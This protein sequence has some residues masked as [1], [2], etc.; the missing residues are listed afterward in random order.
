MKTLH[1]VDLDNLDISQTIIT[2]DYKNK[3]DKKDYR[4]YYIGMSFYIGKWVTV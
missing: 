1:Q 4:Y 2:D 3:V